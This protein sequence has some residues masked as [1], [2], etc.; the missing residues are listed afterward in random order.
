MR[1][2]F[3]TCG[4][5][6]LAHAHDR[7]SKYIFNGTNRV[8]DQPPL[9]TV[10]GCKKLCGAGTEYYPWKDAANTITTWVLPI[11]GLIVQAPWES[12][13]AWET[14]L[15]LFRYMGSPISVLAYVL[16][17]IKVS[18]KAALMVDMSVRYDEYPGEG[19]EFS[20]MRDSMY[21]LCVMNQYSTRPSL[22]PVESELLLRITVFDTR[23][24]LRGSSEDRDSIVAQRTELARGLREGRK[25]GVIPV[26]ISFLWFVFALGLSIELAY[27]D[28][29]GN[30]TAHNLAMGLLVGWLP[31]LVVA[32]TVDRNSVSADSVRERLNNLVKEV[33]IAL[34]EPRTLQEYKTA[35]NHDEGDLA[36]IEALRES[37]SFQEDFFVTFA[38]QGRTH[39]HYGIAHPILS[40]IET[41]FIADYGRGWLRHKDAARKAIVVGSR[42]VNG[43]KMFDMRMVWQLISALLLFCGSTFGS[44]FISWFTPSV[45]LGCRTGGYLIHIV[46]ALGLLL[47]EIGIWSLTH[48]TT[49]TSHDLMRRVS[50]R[51]ERRFT[52]PE[53][54]L[55]QSITTHRLIHYLHSRAFRDVVK[56]VIIQPLEAFNAAWLTYII[57]AQTFGTYQTCTCMGSTW[58]VGKGGFIDFSNAEF[59]Q[60][61]SVYLYWSVGVALSCT[62]MASGL[63]YIVHEYWVEMDEVV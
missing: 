7:Y 9:I 49:H 21:I 36:W 56:A 63:W 8:G 27:D 58:A 25:K 16:W 4:Q 2:N 60:G 61:H 41:K 6:F 54:G 18:G 52:D 53:K 13:Q 47:I 14:I 30:S 1:P 11:I 23:L 57:F 28:I 43:L 12:N 33:R 24:Q 34:L 48:E 10:E 37:D 20:G 44:F 29:G 50:T 15:A 19:T 3:E 32:S 46:T 42:N 22:P 38:G 62:V 59:Y 39:F 45:G 31:V 5:D 17:N 40:G 35:M 51:L 26:F 55:Q